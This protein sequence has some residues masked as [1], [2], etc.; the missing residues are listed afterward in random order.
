MTGPHPYRPDLA[1][2]HHAGFGFH[3]DACAPGILRL[4][5]PL[6]GRDATVLEV[7]CGSGLLT[8]HLLDAGHRV[9][10]TDASPAMLDL[11]RRHAPEALEHRRLVLPDD[12]MP[13]ADAV[14]ST[15]HVLSYLPDADAVMAA[16][17]RCARALRPGGLLALD[18][19]DLTLLD[20]QLGRETGGYVDEDWAMVL[21]RVSDGPRH[22]ARVMTTFVRTADGNWRRDDERHDNVLLDVATEV[23]PVLRSRGPRGVDP[24]GLRSGTVPVD[25]GAAD[26]GGPTTGGLSRPGGAAG[27]QAQRLWPNR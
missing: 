12:P 24:L 3:A 20:G 17:R 22:F 11:A 21:R 1:R 18:L 6:L 15:G 26:R 25:G 23:P 8:R 9:V 19:E 10:A 2:I 16:L 13:E 27:D 4:L 7:G 14:V 5:E